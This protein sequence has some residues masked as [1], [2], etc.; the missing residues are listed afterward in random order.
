MKGLLDWWRCGDQIR[1]YPDLERQVLV[2]RF[3]TSSSIVAASMTSTFVY[4]PRLSPQCPHDQLSF[5]LPISVQHLRPG[6]TWLR[7][8]RLMEY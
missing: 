2:G 1:G 8:Q 5:A 6:H 7:F 4:C 3:G